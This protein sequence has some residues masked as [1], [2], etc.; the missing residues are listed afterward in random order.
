MIE[1]VYNNAKNM[2]VGHMSFEL[3][4]G[5]NAYVLFENEANPCLKSGSANKLAK[6]LRNLLLICQQNLFHAKKL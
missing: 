2:S 5:Y 4:Y 3:N 1:F 6:K